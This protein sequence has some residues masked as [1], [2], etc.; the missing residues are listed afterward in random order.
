M[1]RPNINLLQAKARGM[2]DA[3]LLAQTATGRQMAQDALA[4]IQQ[5]IREERDKPWTIQIKGVLKGSGSTAQDI[6]AVWTQRHPDP[7]RDLTLED[8]DELQEILEQELEGRV[9]RAKSY[10][11]R[12]ITTIKRSRKKMAAQAESSGKPE[13]PRLADGLNAPAWQTV[14]PAR[15]DDSRERIRDLWVEKHA[16][17]VPLTLQTAQELLGILEQVLEERPGNYAVEADRERCRAVIG[18]LRGLE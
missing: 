8:L 13:W 12:T 7:D 4:D 6:L 18:R 16:F 11:R 5:Q 2:E 14:V 9:A 15:K 1:T 3:L 17:G 10:I